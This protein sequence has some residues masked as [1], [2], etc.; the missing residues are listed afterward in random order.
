MCLAAVLRSASRDRAGAGGSAAPRRARD[1]GS[2]AAS[3]GCSDPGCGAAAGG[4]WPAGQ[5]ARPQGAHPSWHSGPS[6]ALQHGTVKMCKQQGLGEYNTSLLLL[7][8]PAQAPAKAPAKKRASA[9]ACT[10]EGEESEYEPG[11][12]S[13]ASDDEVRS[14]HMP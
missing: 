12:A 13:E 9:A 8:A 4:L 7:Q 3:A 10:A 1:A 11:A 14:Q 6:G 5:E 2:A